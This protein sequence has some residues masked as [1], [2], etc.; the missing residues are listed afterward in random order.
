MTSK[1]KRNVAPFPKVKV[2]NLTDAPLFIG[3]K[4]DKA[5][6]V[7]LGPNGQSTDNFTFIG[8]DLSDPRVRNTLRDLANT[9]KVTITV[10]E[11]LDKAIGITTST[12]TTAGG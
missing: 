3:I 11:T 6:G 8:L 7:W 1:K 12:T 10:V 5:S 4:S 9:G 2:T